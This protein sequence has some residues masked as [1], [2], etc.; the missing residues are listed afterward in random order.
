MGQAHGPERD[1]EVGRRVISCKTDH[2]RLELDPLPGLGRGSDHPVSATDHRASGI[3]RRVSETGRLE[4]DD[5][6]GNDLR[7]CDHQGMDLANGRPEP[8]HRDTGHRDK[9]LRVTDHQVTVHLA[10]VICRIMVAGAGTTALTTGGL[11]QL[12]VQ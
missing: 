11:G 4:L 12:L 5:H 3:D 2:L 10:P 7:E 8:G 9:D 6:P 1:P